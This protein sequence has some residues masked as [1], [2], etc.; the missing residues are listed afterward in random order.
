MRSMIGGCP[1]QDLTNVGLCGARGDDIVIGND[2]SPSEECAMDATDGNSASRRTA[3]KLALIVVIAS[4]AQ[5]VSPAATVPGGGRMLHQG[6][7]VTF[8]SWAVNRPADSSTD[9]R[10][11]FS[12]VVGGQ[13]GRGRFAGRILS[14]ARTPHPRLWLGHARYE[15][16]GGNHVLIADV[17]I[18]ENEEMVPTTATIQGVVTS[19]WL[20]GARVTGRYT[21][22]DWCGV[23]TPGNVS[24]TSCIRGSLQ[25]APRST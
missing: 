6:A 10:V 19:G 15:F 1:D 24:G 5:S 23:P 8:T 20:R 11:R 18:T 22:W 13:V 25:V 3:C 7:S 17:D 16:H 9:A 14:D 21:R 2:E 12:G 4:L